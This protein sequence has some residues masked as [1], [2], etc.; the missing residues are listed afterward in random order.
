MGAGMTKK[1]GTPGSKDKGLDGYARRSG[2]GRLRRANAKDGSRLGNLERHADD[3]G[4]LDRIGSSSRRGNSGETLLGK[5]NRLARDA[6]SAEG[7]PGRVTGF[8]G[9]DVLVRDEAGERPA[10]VRRLL[11]KMRHGERNVLAVG[12]RVRVIDDGADRAVVVGVEPRRNQLAR[13]DSHNKALEQVLAANIDRLVIVAAVALPDLKPGLID[14]YLLLAHL[15]EIEPVIVINKG[16]LG[17]A[18]QAQ[19]LYR[20]LGYA[21]HLTQAERGGE[22]PGVVA[23]RT[24]LRGLSCVISGQSGVG[25]SSLVAA[26]HPG[27]SLRIGA[28]SDAQAKGRHT[29]NASRSYLLPDGIELIDTPGIRECGV[30]KIEPLDVALH[31]RD[32]AALQP[33][34]HFPDCTHRHEPGCA[35]LRALEEGRLALSRYDSYCKI[36]AGDLG[37]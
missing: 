19:A 11:K 28:V 31:Y 3:D 5:F 17:D 34:C 15:H 14:R 2:M 7:R 26:L 20:S 29:T 22:D 9:A 23:L 18:G 4:F 6:A 21:V 30:G 16:D 25:K 35:V 27:L 10:S 24:E 37:W 33:Q 12:D 13:A 36:I 8:D 1:R 32:L